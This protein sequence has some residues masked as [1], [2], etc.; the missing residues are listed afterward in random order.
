MKYY[1]LHFLF[2]FFFFSHTAA[3]QFHTT[4]T[5]SRTTLDLNNVVSLREYKLAPL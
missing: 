5:A 4:P 3:A 2:L 1:R